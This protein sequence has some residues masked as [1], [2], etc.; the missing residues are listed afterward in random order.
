M[1]KKQYI[2]QLF[3]SMGHLRK[4]MENRVQE[5]HEEK[6]ATMMQFSALTF[7]KTKNNSTVGDIA[8]QLKLSSSSATQLIERLVKAGSVKRVDDKNDRRIVRLAITTVGEQEIISLK[9]KLMDKM[10]KILS[11][12]PDED[13][14]ELVRIHTNLIETLQKEQNS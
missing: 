11:K 7:L 3:N 1:S 10:S 12:I 9:K 6:T 5:S 14:K 13:L 8:V 2:E 4:L